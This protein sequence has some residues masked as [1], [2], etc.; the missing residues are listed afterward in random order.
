M[1]M[2]LTGNFFWWHVIG[3]NCS[4]W[5][6]MALYGDIMRYHG[7]ILE[8]YGVYIYNI[9]FGVQDWG[10]QLKGIPMVFTTSTSWET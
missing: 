5:D 10:Y 4:L 7:D 1:I 8:I 3:F 2:V 9:L 6:L